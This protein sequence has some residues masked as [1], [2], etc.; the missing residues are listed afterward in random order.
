MVLDCAVLAAARPTKRPKPDV[1]APF[2]FF[3]SS[4]S[5]SILSFYYVA[6][7]IDGAAAKPLAYVEL[8]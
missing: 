7:T 3:A 2:L 4:S 1:S 5:S 8:F 6:F